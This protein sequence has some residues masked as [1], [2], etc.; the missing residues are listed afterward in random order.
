[1]LLNAQT[2]DVFEKNIYYTAFEKPLGQVL[3]ELSTRTKVN[4]SFNPA[5]IPEGQL[6]S[7]NI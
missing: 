3:V 2:V 6:I 1:M 4:I 7:I 5:I